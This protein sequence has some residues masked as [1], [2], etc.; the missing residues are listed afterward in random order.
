MNRMELAF[1]AHVG[2]QPNHLYSVGIFNRESDRS[3]LM[4]GSKAQTPWPHG[5]RGLDFPFR[6]AE[7][8][9][10]EFRQFEE[11]LNAIFRSILWQAVV[12]MARRFSRLKIIL[13]LD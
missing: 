4:S 11:S 1:E 8:K 9:I 13:R 3:F 12:R 7:P 5:M 6:L 2:R 10:P